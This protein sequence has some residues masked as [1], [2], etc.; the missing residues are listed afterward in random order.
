MDFQCKPTGG[1][2]IRRRIRLYNS[3]RQVSEASCRKAGERG[4]AAAAPPR[5]GAE[6]HRRLH[7]NSVAIKPISSGVHLP[8][9]HGVELTVSPLTSSSD[10][11][12]FECCRDFTDVFHVYD[13]EASGHCTDSTL[14]VFFLLWL[15]YLSFHLPPL[16]A[17]KANGLLSCIAL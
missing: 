1:A 17:F 9:I 11:F 6:S 3:N 14:F 15:L 10:V 5:L 8:Y 4:R 7:W 16:R 13:A 12:Q 2:R